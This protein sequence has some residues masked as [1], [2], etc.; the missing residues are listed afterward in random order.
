[1]LTGLQ[2]SYFC[3]AQDSYGTLWSPVTGVYF[4]DSLKA[5]AKTY[6]SLGPCLWTPN[7]SL[8]LHL[9]FT[10]NSLSDTFKICHS[11]AQNHPIASCLTKNKIPNLHQG[12]YD[13]VPSSITSSL[14]ITFSL[15]S[16]TV[17]QLFSFYFCFYTHQAC[18]CLG[19]L[20]LTGPSA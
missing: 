3:I 19:T 16:P 1:M 5:T 2:E 10:T 13:I 9:V 20:M 7:L 14:T 15:D 17:F 8:Q 6:V 4:E 11:S 18:S 12:L